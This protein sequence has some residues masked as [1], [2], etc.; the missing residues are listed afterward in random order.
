MRVLPTLIRD[1]PRAPD[2]AKFDRQHGDRLLPLFEKS[3][4]ESFETVKAA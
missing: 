2:N 3:L 1:G 4:K